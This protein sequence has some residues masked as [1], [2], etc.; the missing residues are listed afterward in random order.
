[1]PLNDNV[2]LPYQFRHSAYNGLAL[3]LFALYVDKNRFIYYNI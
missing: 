1:M 3:Q 2:L